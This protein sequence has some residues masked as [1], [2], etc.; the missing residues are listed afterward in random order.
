ME[1]VRLEIE[2]MM[3]VAEKQVRTHY[4]PVSMSNLDTWNRM[5]E[6]KRMQ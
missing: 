5:Y 2:N 1:A 4:A 6:K 3:K